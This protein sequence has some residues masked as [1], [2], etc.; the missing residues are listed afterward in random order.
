MVKW[1]KIIQREMKPL[2]KKKEEKPERLID[3]CS[4]GMRA[5]MHLA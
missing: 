3:M 1:L 4:R 5:L 2:L